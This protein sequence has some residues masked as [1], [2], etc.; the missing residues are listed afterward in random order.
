MTHSQWHVCIVDV[1]IWEFEFVCMCALTV[2][3]DFL[4]HTLFLI[5]YRY[6]CHHQ[7][8]AKHGRVDKIRQFFNG[9]LCVSIFPSSHYLPILFS[10]NP[11]FLLV[12]PQLDCRH[13]SN[14][15]TFIRRRPVE[16]KTSKMLLRRLVYSSITDKYPKV[17][18]WL[19]V[20]H[21]HRLCYP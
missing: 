18:I 17:T 21:E 10:S 3:E 19:I 1:W 15:G 2:Q 9:Q 5:Q 7:V 14:V 12:E 8:D 11:L 4:L 16:G 13:F 20:P 6:K